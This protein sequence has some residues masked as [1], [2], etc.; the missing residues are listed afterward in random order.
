MSALVGASCRLAFVRLRR[1]P[2]GGGISAF[3]VELQGIVSTRHDD[4]TFNVFTPHSGVT[5]EHVEPSLVTITG[6]P[7]DDKRRLAVN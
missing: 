1:H 2:E 3:P 6:F 5:H 7:T 4:G